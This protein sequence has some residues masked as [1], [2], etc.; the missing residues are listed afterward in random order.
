VRWVDGSKHPT[1]LAEA[2]CWHRAIEVVCRCGHRSSFDPHGLW[3]WFEQRRWD[4]RLSAVAR[5]FWCRPCR[6]RLNRK[7]RPVTV[8]CLRS[9]DADVCLPLP[10]E[11]VWKRVVSRMRY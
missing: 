2:A 4:S 1:D 7:V 5:R 9:S 11:R 10:D 3:W 8:D 6:Q